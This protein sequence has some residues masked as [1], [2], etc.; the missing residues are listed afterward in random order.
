MIEGEST[1]T[2]LPPLG[3]I[4]SNVKM[5]YVLLSLLGLGFRVSLAFTARSVRLFSDS[6]PEQESDTCLLSTAGS[7]VPPPLI[8]APIAHSTP[9]FFDPLSIWPTLFG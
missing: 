6:Y 9:L 4:D 1:D 8:T 5:P 2:K 3:V 7:T